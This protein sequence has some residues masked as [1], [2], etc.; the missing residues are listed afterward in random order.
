M[1]K[2]LTDMDNRELFITLTDAQNVLQ[3]AQLQRIIGQYLKFSGKPRL[4]YD[5]SE[6]DLQT[7]VKE[8]YEGKYAE[9][10]D[11]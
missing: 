8:Y 3:R 2:P 11:A 1:N 5:E 7:I 6:T 10:G 9:T 4:I